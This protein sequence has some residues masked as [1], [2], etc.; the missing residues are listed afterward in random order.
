MQKGKM[1]TYCVQ[2]IDEKTGSYNTA[3]F[4]DAINDRAA[5]RYAYQNFIPFHGNK[6]QAVKHYTLSALKKGAEATVAN[7]KPLYIRKF[8]KSNNGSRWYPV[9]KTAKAS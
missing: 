1:K 5:K 8:D 3:E 6:R 7:T 4:F 2:F 9:K